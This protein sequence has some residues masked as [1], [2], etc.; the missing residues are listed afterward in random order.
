MNAK[1]ALWDDLARR[2]GSLDCKPFIL[3]MKIAGYGKTG[4]LG[5]ISCVRSPA[6]SFIREIGLEID[7]VGCSAV[8]IPLFVGKPTLFLHSGRKQAHLKTDY[9]FTE[10]FA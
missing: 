1:A 7:S 10:V 2:N 3:A 6:L 4:T 5:H 9:T 8:R